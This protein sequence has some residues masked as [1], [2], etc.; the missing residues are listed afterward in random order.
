M[1]TGQNAGDFFLAKIP[2]FRLY[3]ETLNSLKLPN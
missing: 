2:A 3:V 1:Q